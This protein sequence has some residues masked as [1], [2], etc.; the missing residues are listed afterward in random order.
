MCKFEVHMYLRFRSFNL[1]FR[2]MAT[3]TQTDRHTYTRVLQ[4]SPASVGLAQARPNYLFSLQRC[5]CAY[6]ILTYIHVFDTLHLISCQN[7]NQQN[8]N[9][10]LEDCTLRCRLSFISHSSNSTESGRWT[11]GVLSYLHLEIWSQNVIS[12]NSF[13]NS[14]G[15]H[16]AEQCH[17]RHQQNDWRLHFCAKYLCCS[18]IIY[19]TPPRNSN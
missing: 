10:I 13:S 4:C 18:Y 16:K 14:H 3:H 6:L 12:L 8:Q 11:S 19:L 15:Q 17:I 7:Q 1:N 2:Y 5:L 9:C